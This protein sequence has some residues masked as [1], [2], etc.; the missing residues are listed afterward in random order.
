MTHWLH[1]AK[2]KQEWEYWGGSVDQW[3]RHISGFE[4]NIYV[5]VMCEI[6]FEIFFDLLPPPPSPPSYLFAQ[7]R[8]PV[9][10]INS[11][12]SGSIISG[13]LRTYI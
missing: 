13:E 1:A 11:S 10:W 2:A 5:W 6:I 12:C 4:P 8:L 3:I 9:P 7:L